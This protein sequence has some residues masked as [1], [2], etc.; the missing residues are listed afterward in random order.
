MNLRYRVELDNEERSALTA[1]LSGGKQAARKLKRAQVLLAA[2]RGLDDAAIGATVGVIG[3]TVY[4]VKRA[5]AV[6]GFEAALEEEPRPGAKRQAPGE[7][8]GLAGAGVSG[9]LC[10]GPV[11]F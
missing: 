3:S 8:G 6:E 7:G 11:S 9:I 2:G 4:R 5:F 1:M 10:A